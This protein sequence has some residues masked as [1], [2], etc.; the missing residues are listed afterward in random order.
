MGRKSALEILADDKVSIETML[1]MTLLPLPDYRRAVQITSQYAEFIKS[2]TA[3][4]EQ[5]LLP[6]TPK[7]TTVNEGTIPSSK[8]VAPAAPVAPAAKP[9]MKTTVD[10]NVIDDIFNSVQGL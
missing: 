9:A 10:S 8:T 7:P 6:N 2:T 1:K 5:Q 4:A 3:K